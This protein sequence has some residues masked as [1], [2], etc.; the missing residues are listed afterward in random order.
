MNDSYDGTIV[1]RPFTREDTAI[2]H[3][4]F[5]HLSERTRAFF[6]G[7]PFTRE[8]AERLTGDDVDQ[9]D[10]RRFLA[11]V[12]SPEEET[13]IGYV[14]YWDWDKKVPWFGISVRDD[15]QGIGLGKKMMD[16]SIA[17][18]KR[19]HKGG[20]LLTTRKDNASGQALYKRSGFEMIGDDP[21]GELLMILNFPAKG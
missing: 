8:E 6:P 5:E 2:V 4:Y 16:F 17:E 7:Y 11:S 3:R 1:I 20:I 13:M 15:Y 21:R 9:S 14:F 18:A 19:H 10:T 12:Q